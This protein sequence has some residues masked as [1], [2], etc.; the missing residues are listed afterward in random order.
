MRGQPSAAEGQGPP[1]VAPRQAG[2]RTPGAPGAALVLA[3]AGI[4]WA[5]LDV[6]G[7]IAAKSDLA[8]GPSPYFVADQALLLY[9]GAPL[10]IL[11]ASALFL[12]PGL[13]LT[14]AAGRRD[15]RFELWLLKGFTLSVFGVPTLAAIVQTASGLEVVG[16]AYV[17]F[18]LF[19]CLP[20]LALLARRGAPPLFAGRATDIAVMTLVPALVLVALAPKFH[21]EA[22]NADGAH[23]F[24][25]AQL[26]VS[27]GLPFWPPESTLAGYPS[28]TMMTETFLQ[29]GLVRVFGAH[30]A[31]VRA[32]FLPGVAVLAGVLLS[33]V[34]D[35]AGRT[36]LP[37]ALGIAA[38]L[39]LFSF[40]LA[41]NPS[42]NSYFAEVALPMVREPPILLG[43]LGYVLFFL[44]RRPVWMAVVSTLALLTAS[45]G[46][47]LIGFFLGAYFL[48]T[49][50]LPFRQVIG[51]GL[52]AL[53]VSVLALTA[54]EIL[55]ALGVTRTS[56]EFGAAAILTRLRFVTIFD[57]QK[58]LFWLLPCGLLPGLALLAWR[59]QDRLSR[60][61][62]ITT[63]AY[64][65]FFYVQA[66]RILPHHFAPAMVLPLIVFW[67]LRPVQAFRTP[68][69]AMALG[70]LLAG[71]WMSWPDTL[72]PNTY[73]R[74][75]SKRVVISDAGGAPLDIERMNAVMALLHDA[76]P[77]LW[78]DAD[79][80]KRYL[81]E[82][83]AVYVYARATTDPAVVADYAIRSA[84]EA[85]SGGETIIGETADGY[86]L[87]VRK[88]AIFEKDLKA[89]GIPR[90]ISEAYRV[91]RKK[92]F[93]YGARE[94]PYPVWD[95]AKIAGLR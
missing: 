1:P 72:R 28:T 64:V 93:G 22:L 83:P 69:L 44:E 34:R 70:G 31:A 36:P 81:L 55:D 73:A 50:P 59:W 8:S 29:A 20:G 75:F 71:A 48:L 35:Q 5:G 56:G 11:A 10:V 95:L 17:L 30:E 79:L 15:E 68:A 7:S 74:E 89:P 19:L 3:L 43:F 67:R 46:I 14:L 12:A 84:T 60:M 4:S 38:A 37:P 66:Y 77:R 42:Y 26:F 41:F 53:A 52:I 13:L 76:F 62:T 45:N 51:G 32:A 58:M 94:E 21:W 57:T 25:S 33:F 90:S 16:G 39:L 82:P 92:I 54:M 23:A 18:L 27:K 85:V 91:P 87:V 63:L 2:I 9:V 6:V 88:R 24:L 47:L 78:T 86:V 65:L 40:V 49:R 80:R 61:L